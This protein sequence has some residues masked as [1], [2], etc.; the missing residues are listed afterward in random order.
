MY[1]NL[2]IRLYKKC[3][4]LTVTCS[5]TIQI[6]LVTITLVTIHVFAVY[7]CPLIRLSVYSIKLEVSYRTG[8]FHQGWKCKWSVTGQQLETTE[9]CIKKCAKRTW[10]ITKNWSTTQF[11]IVQMLLKRRKL[12]AKS[13][14]LVKKFKKM[15]IKFVS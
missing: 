7:Y 13:C 8:S 1:T 10:Q 6:T 11:K 5:C 12:I 2:Q 15:F 3:S 14:T 4:E 9:I